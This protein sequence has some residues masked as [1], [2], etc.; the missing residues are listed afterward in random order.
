MRTSSTASHR[1]AKSCKQ[2]LDELLLLLN[3]VAPPVAREH[4]RGAERTAGRS[5][6]DSGNALR[7][8]PCHRPS[9]QPWQ[10]ASSHGLRFRCSPHRRRPRRPPAPAA[11]SSRRRTTS[12]TMR[13]R[14]ASSRPCWRASTWSSKCATT[15]FRC[16]RAMWPSSRWCAR[17]AVPELLR[18]TAVSRPEAELCAASS[19]S[20]SAIWACSM[21]TACAGLEQPRYAHSSRGE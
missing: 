13:R 17:R 9:P 5:R 3:V 1:V 7:T 18:A 16:R 11:P 14:C 4:T 2:E 15:A 8:R 6:A 12:A 20:P 10:H 19:S 21:P